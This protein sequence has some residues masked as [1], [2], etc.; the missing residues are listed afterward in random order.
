MLGI[1]LTL[2]L[3]SSTFALIP[4]QESAY[5]KVYH[6]SD[7]SF[8]ELKALRSRNKYDTI[9][10]TTENPYNGTVPQDYGGNFGDLEFVTTFK[11]GTLIGRDTIINENS[12]QNL[13]VLYERRYNTSYVEDFKLL[14]FGRQR[15]WTWSATIHHNT[16]LV[17]ADILIA[18]GNKVRILAET[19]ARV[20]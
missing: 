18:A 4:A 12:F 3:A 16:G 11:N 15:G 7:I 14:N 17:T 19:Y 9:R 20:Y 8:E 6:I 2:F 5:Y 1:V 10:S 13:L